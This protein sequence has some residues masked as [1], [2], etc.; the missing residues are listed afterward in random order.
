MMMSELEH[1]LLGMAQINERWVFSS[2]IQP[3]ASNAGTT[4]THSIARTET[5]EE[6]EYARYLTEIEVRKRRVAEQQA[7]L[8]AYR[9]QLGRFNVEYHTRVG[10]LF[11][12]LD[13]IELAIAEYE[14]RIAQLRA[15]PQLE[16]EELEHRARQAFAE[17]REQIHDDEEETRYYERQHREE[18]TRPELDDVS[19]GTLRT[20]YLELVKRFHPDLSKTE[21][22]RLQREAV[23]KEVNAAFHERNIE[24]LQTIGTQHHVDET[25]FESKSIGEKLVWAIREISRLDDL[26][27]EIQAQRAILQESEL[28]RLWSLYETEKHPL[29]HLEDDLRSQLDQKRKFLQTLVVDF[30]S[31]TD[32]RHF[33]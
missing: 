21:E 14:F 26:I 27:E 17:Q 11:V 28:A 10:V 32:K 2:C 6:R 20:L 7:D 18:Q 31:L 15:D 8:A 22:E 24:Q 3:S 30:R 12:E 25:A 19:M 33:G 4:L 5:P 9:E 23:M 16:P 29:D 1:A 13:R